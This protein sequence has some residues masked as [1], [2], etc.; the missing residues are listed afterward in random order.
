M[1]PVCHRCGTALNSESNLFCPHCGVPQLR[2]EPVDD[3]SASFTPSQQTVVGRNLEFVSWKTAVSSASVVAIPVG[4]LS[5]ILPVALFWVI[6]G[7]IATVSLYHRRVRTPATGRM[8]WRIGGLLGLLA[9]SISTAFDS[10]KLVVLRYLLHSNEFDRQLHLAM[11]QSADMVNHLFPAMAD[12]MAQ[13]VRF[14]ISPDGTAAMV[15]FNAAVSAFFMVLFGA[16]GGAIGARITSLG[17]RAER[18]SQ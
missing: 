12:A 2:Y 15:L 14:W 5:S 7:G 16:A 13:S 18:S 10:L 11:Q 6:C 9:A 1:D 8:G 17:P 4:L 3:P